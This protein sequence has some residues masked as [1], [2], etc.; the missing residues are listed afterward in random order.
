MSPGQTNAARPLSVTSLLAIALLAIFGCRTVR[1]V[2]T[3]PDENRLVIEQ[4]EIYTDFRLPKQHRLLAE[5]TA[6]RA[7][8]SADLSL[9]VSDEP[10]RV[11]LFETGDEFRRFMNRSYPTFP[12]RR[13]FFIETDTRLS[14][15]AYWGDRIAED[16]RHEVAH[17]YLHAVVPNLPLWLDE[18]LAEYFEVSRGHHGLNRPH[19]Q[20]LL[21][22]YEQQTW[23]PELARL[24]K[25]ESV[26][27]MQQVDYAEA[28]AW[29]H[30]MLHSTAGRRELM[31]DT[32]RSLRTQARTQP[33]S[34]SLRRDS[35]R[36]KKDGA[37]L[38]KQTA[39]LNAMLLEHLSKI[40]GQGK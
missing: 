21:Y 13:A 11:Y 35:R 4:L 1:P 39:Q 8:L 26:A 7:D 24:E 25:L 15:Y 23:S 28:W 17:G 14:V 37:A 32:L 22:R 2:P 6:L 19:L 27:D 16:L 30:L 33:L 9:P 40:T 34:V 5:L 10:I 29:V 18:G 31:L 12:T 3:L 36:L 38:P 20:E